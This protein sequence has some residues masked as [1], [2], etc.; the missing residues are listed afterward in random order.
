MTDDP[1]DLPSR[2]PVKS[3]PKPSSP[4][5][6]GGGVDDWDEDSEDSKPG[7]TS[8][9]PTRAHSRPHLLASYAM[10]EPARRDE[11]DM[12]LAPP[13]ARSRSALQA[14]DE[15]DEG[16]GAATMA[17]EGD[18][19]QADNDEEEEVEEEE[20]PIW[21]QSIDQ[22]VSQSTSAAALDGR[23]VAAS[24][25][26][27]ATVHSG[28]LV[29]DGEEQALS[30]VTAAADAAA[31]EPT[32]AQASAHTGSATGGEHSTTA[33]RFKGSNP[34]SLH[35]E[36]R[37]HSGQQLRKAVADAVAK[38]E[39]RARLQQERAVKRAI[40]AAAEQ[41]R[42]EVCMHATRSLTLSLPCHTLV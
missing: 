10:D 13:M 14:D 4:P 7:R 34:P 37:V 2:A 19:E 5:P 21:D 22:S 33:P 31:S 42:Q 20:E 12:S 29:L 40:E 23:T 32:G 26:T 1:F 15:W 35:E 8:A 6:K 11:A 24:E 38:V 17:D 9:Q 41:L 27:W 39:E 28:G 25:E 36:G 3:P 16:D 18:E 30:R